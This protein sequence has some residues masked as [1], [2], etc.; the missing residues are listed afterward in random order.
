MEKGENKK[1][2]YKEFV[3]DM[4]LK[5]Y[6]ESIVSPSLKDPIPFKYLY[7]Y[8]KESMY[9]SIDFSIFRFREVASELKNKILNVLKI[10]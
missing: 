10:N 2:L 8:E 6:Y 9:K 5:K 7:D 3:K 4:M 1:S